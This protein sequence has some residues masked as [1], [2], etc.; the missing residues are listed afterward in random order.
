MIGASNG[1]SSLLGFFISR[2]P[3]SKIYVFPFPIPVPA[4]LLG[5]GYFYFNYRGFYNYDSVGYAGHLT[6]FL[7][8]LG[9]HYI[10]K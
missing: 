2:F 8:G 9:Y 1:V 7:T 3:W 4:W 5:M 6:G 10:S